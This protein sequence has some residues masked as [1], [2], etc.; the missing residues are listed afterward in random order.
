[1]EHDFLR[2]PIEVGAL[3]ATHRAAGRLEERIDVA[4]RALSLNRVVSLQPAGNS[5]T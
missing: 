1:M 3:L 2:L 4:V 5:A